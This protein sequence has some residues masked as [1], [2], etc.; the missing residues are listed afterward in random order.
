[1]RRR[2]NVTFTIIL[3]LLAV[4]VVGCGQTSDTGGRASAS[5]DAEGSAPGFPVSIENCGRT[6]TF[7]EPPSKVVVSFQPTLE[8]LVSLGVGDRVIGRTNSLDHL[9]EAG[10]LPG[11]EQIIESIP[12]VTDGTRPPVKEELLALQPDFVFG[13][14]FADFDAANGLATVEELN[15]VGI[16]VFIPS[17]WC[18]RAAAED[19]RFDVTR[20]F[21]DIRDLGRIFGVTDR[22]EELATGLEARLADVQERVK[23]L[24]PVEVVA[25]DAS[26]EIFYAL[27]KGMGNSIIT[28]AGGTNLF[29]DVGEYAEVSVEEVAAR[30]AEAYM[31]IDYLPLTPADRIETIEKVAPQSDGV[32]DKRYIVIPSV[33]IHPGTRVVDSIETL[34]RALHPEAFTS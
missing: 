34:A 5:G 33:G 6:L 12:E 29:S 1:M 22:A 7:D 10:F 15:E 28:M 14:S 25:P 32:Q 21:Q 27:G 20:T 16:P 24:P 4:W 26:D 23:G 13:M 2:N 18:D 31:I 17:N 19:V 9:G 11:Q 30:N 3:L 8:T